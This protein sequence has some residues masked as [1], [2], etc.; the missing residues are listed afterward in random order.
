MMNNLEPSILLP[1]GVPVYVSEMAVTVIEKKKTWKRRG[2][3]PKVKTRAIVKP[4]M[5]VVNMS[6]QMF[7]F[8]PG[9]ARQVIYA[10]PAIV[11]KL[12]Q[13]QYGAGVRKHEMPWWITGECV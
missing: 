12:K 5:F 7:F 11:E 13:A 10:H 2:R 1:T 3:M 6:P 4:G 8:P 9:P